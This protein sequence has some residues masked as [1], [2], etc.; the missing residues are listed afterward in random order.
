ME[1]QSDFYKSCREQIKE[2]GIE[3]YKLTMYHFKTGVKE[4][5]Y[6]LPLA[7]VL[8]I[9]KNVLDEYE[10]TLITK[11]QTTNEPNLFNQ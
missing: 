10:L 2:N 8:A 6:N 3:Q 4:T 9:M 11:D 1:Q 7:R 5:P